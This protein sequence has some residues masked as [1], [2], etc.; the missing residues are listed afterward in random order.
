MSLKR[1]IRRFQDKQENAGWRIQMI[2]YD[3]VVKPKAVF[4]G[5]ATTGAIIFI[6]GFILAFNAVRPGQLPVR[7]SIN[8]GKKIGLALVIAGLLL[9][10][11]GIWFKA[12]RK[13]KDWELTD[14]RCVDR[15]LKKIW[16]TDTRT[17]AGFWGWFWR[18][19]CEYEYSG[20]AVRVT[21]TVYW[22]NFTSEPA[23]MKFLEER[24]S[25]DGNCKLHI[26]PKNPLQTELV[27]QGIKDKLVY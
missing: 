5:V 1:K 16:L 2:S 22:S 19:I 4:N 14:A 11:F 24:I 7:F 26:N 21:P 13:R 12:R 17:G 6:I 15:E 18:I 10:L 8:H 20:K 27:G 23:A 9:A 25:P 3:D